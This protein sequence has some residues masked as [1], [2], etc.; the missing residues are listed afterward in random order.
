VLLGNPIV[1]TTASDTKF[2]HMNSRAGKALC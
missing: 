1:F 2:A